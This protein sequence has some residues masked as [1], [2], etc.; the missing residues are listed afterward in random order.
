MTESRR[1]EE[2][3]VGGAPLR[4]EGRRCHFLRPSTGLAPSDPKPPVPSPFQGSVTGG[5]AAFVPFGTLLGA[6]KNRP[7]SL[8]FRDTYKVQPFALHSQKGAMVP[9]RTGEKKRLG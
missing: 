6:S 7:D 4:R 9:R 3:G 1:N 5:Y 8:W 2:P